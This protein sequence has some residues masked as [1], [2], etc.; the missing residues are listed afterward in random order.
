M[1]RDGSPT[2]DTPTS[3]LTG[4]DEHPREGEHP[5]G[6]EHPVGAEHSS[7]DEHLVGAERQ[8]A[9]EHPGSR[10]SPAYSSASST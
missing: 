5:V 8:G 6:D 3:P 7:G 4:G 10:R 2:A 1:K 9:D